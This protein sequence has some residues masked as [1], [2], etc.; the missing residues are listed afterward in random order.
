MLNDVTPNISLAGDRG[1]GFSDITMVPATV[2]V[3]VTVAEVMVVVEVV[4]TISGTP[5]ALGRWTRA[6]VWRCRMRSDWR[7]G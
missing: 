1:R 5:A 4:V 7:W 3:V 6:A 2:V